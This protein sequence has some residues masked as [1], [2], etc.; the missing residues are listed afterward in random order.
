MKNY[1]P[2]LFLLGLFWTCGTSRNVKLPST[3]VPKA[4]RN[5]MDSASL[6]NT[7][8]KNDLKSPQ[9]YKT[10]T[11]NFGNLPWK[12]LFADSGLR[13]LIDTALLR[14]YDFLLA[15]KNVEEAKATNKQVKWN[16]IPQASLNIA[17]STTRP[18]DNSINGLSIASYGLP[19]HIEDYNT[20]VLFSW[21]AD[22]WGKIHR[23]K[24]SSLAN[25]LGTVEVKRAIQTGLIASIAKSYY[26]LKMLNHQ[27]SIVKKN[28]DLEDSTVLIIQLQY[29]SGQ[30]TSLAVDQAQAQALSAKAL[31][32]QFEQAIQI[33]ENS[34]S[35]LAGSFPKNILNT[36]TDYPYFLTDH[37]SSG[38]PSELLNNRPDVKSKE[39]AVVIADAKLGNSKIA[40]YPSL[41]ITASGGLNSY[42]ASNWYNIPGSLFGIVG[43]SLV[44]PLINNRRLRTQ[45]NIARIEKEKAVLQFRQSVLNAVGE[46]SNALVQIEKLK[47]QYE[48]QDQRVK[49]LQEAILKSKL[50]FRSG[51]ANYLEVITAQN[52]LLQSELELTTLYRDQ[53]IAITELYRSLGGGWN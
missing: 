46:V 33:Q 45:Y 43:G 3:Q 32:L 6:M 14:N 39:F 26:N 36:Q 38:I 4:Y 24:K 20:E 21:E 8:L 23:E 37:F 30:V 40:L 50:L 7:H 35:L 34:L 1:I 9:I 48:L 12:S 42:L 13:M 19:P 49:T 15:V 52:S 18:S 22:I 53:N 16:N 25:Y 28:V 29:N 41:Q 11:S 5:P 44:A 2:F 31:I 51:L 10:D 27:L 17:A 47:L